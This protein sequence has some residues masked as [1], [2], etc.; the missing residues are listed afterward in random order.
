MKTTEM[1]VSSFK[2]M[3]YAVQGPINAAE[4]DRVIIIQRLTAVLDPHASVC[5]TQRARSAT[6]LSPLLTTVGPWALS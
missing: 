2:T 6:G 4:R 3:K 1:N 5:R